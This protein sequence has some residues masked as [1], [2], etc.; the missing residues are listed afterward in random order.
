MCGAIL[1]AIVAVCAAYAIN[2]N[3]FTAVKDKIKGWLSRD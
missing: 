3:I 2:P 1:F